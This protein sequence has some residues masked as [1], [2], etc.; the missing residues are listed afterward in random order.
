MAVV[1]LSCG[2]ARIKVAVASFMQR[3][4]NNIAPVQELKDW[5]VKNPEFFKKRVYTQPG[6]DS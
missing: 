6:L 4:F 3:T 1:I 5:R 2:A